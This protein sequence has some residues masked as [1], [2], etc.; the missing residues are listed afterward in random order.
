M[1]CPSSPTG[2]V[3]TLVNS[4][5]LTESG[6]DMGGPQPLDLLTPAVRRLLRVKRGQPDC[7]CVQYTVHGVRMSCRLGAC[8][9]VDL[10]SQTGKAP[11]PCTVRIM[12]VYEC[13]VPTLMQ[14]PYVM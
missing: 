1:N 2:L 3:S 10:S 12:K 11:L 5:D 13:T 8:S 7:V 6:L 9:K 4:Q 14:P